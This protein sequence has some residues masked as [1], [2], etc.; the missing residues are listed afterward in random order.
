[1][2]TFLTEISAAVL[3]ALVALFG[4]VLTIILRRASDVAQQRWGI[5]IEAR[6]REALQTAVMSGIR[7][8][9]LRG[10]T[11]DAAIK[12]AISH[13]ENSVPDAIAA[14]KPT[15]GVL[16]SIAQGKLQ[17]AESWVVDRQG[18]LG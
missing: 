17:D 3:P 8:A 4:T 18:R 9:M 12:A 6:H 7:A 5:E 16:V 15:A 14:L 13:A 2:N 1:M 11:G 10:L